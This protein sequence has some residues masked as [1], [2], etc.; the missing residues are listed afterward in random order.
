MQK[1]S[2]TA[3]HS[4]VEAVDEMDMQIVLD[5]LIV[6]SDVLDGQDSQQIAVALVDLLHQASLVNVY[7]EY[8]LKQLTPR[9]R[10]VAALLKRGLTNLEMSDSLGCTER[11]IRAHLEHMQQKLNV[12]NRTALLASISGVL[13]GG[14]ANSI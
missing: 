2:A 9:E 6:K 7:V 12:P 8:V 4:V 5:N 11:T 3:I 14:K 10:E 1:P 13:I